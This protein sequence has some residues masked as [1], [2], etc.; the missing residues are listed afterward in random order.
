MLSQL[1]EDYFIQRCPSVDQ[2]RRSSCSNRL[3]MVNGTLCA[4]LGRNNRQTDSDGTARHCN[5]RAARTPTYEISPSRILVRAGLPL[6]NGQ[7]V[8]AARDAQVPVLIS[9]N[10]FAKRKDKEFT[11]F[12]LPE[13]GRYAGMDIAL[14]SAGFVAAVVYGDY[15][16]SVAKYIELAASADWAFWSSMDYCVEPQVAS[17]AELIQFRIAATARL[18]GQCTRAAE[19]AGIKPPMPVLQGW[20]PEHYAHCADLLPL[21]SWP[22]LVGVGSVCRRDVSGPD[23]LI[24]IV[25]AL[26]RIL[27]PHVQFH[28]FGVKS[29]GLK[30]LANHPRIR[31]AD[32]MAWDAALRREM[33]VGRDMQVRTN[34]M[35]EWQRKQVQL[36]N[37]WDAPP[38]AS[39]AELE[40]TPT[41]TLKERVRAAVAKFYGEMQGEFSDSYFQDAYEMSVSLS[42]IEFGFDQHGDAYLDDERLWQETLLFVYIHEELDIPFSEGYLERE[43]Y[44]LKHGRDLPDPD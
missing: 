28:L 30:L 31:S 35:V 29:S 10:A 21:D 8:E 6:P 16:W 13:P 18:L 36:L 40:M 14:D 17:N 2:A 38:P 37:S 26:D 32:S 7:L 4:E 42:W 15:D 25:D 3:L 33:P 1:Q 44:W 43:A 34:A 11:G 22:N 20:R 5:P 27:P 19:K 41:P 24:A 12:R 23:G 9:A 39:Q